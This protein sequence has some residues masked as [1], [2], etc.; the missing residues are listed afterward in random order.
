MV[1]PPSGFIDIVMERSNRTREAI[2]SANNSAFVETRG[3]EEESKEEDRETGKRIYRERGRDNKS[4]Y[5]IF[6]ERGRKVIRKKRVFFRMSFPSA[7]LASDMATWRQTEHAAAIFVFLSLPD[8]M[9]EAIMSLAGS[10][11]YR[12]DASSHACLLSTKSTVFVHGSN[13]TYGLNGNHM[14]QS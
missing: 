9:S 7:V 14:W 10:C 5:L 12:E 1:I 2:V 3:T 4:S 8:C 11:R 13:C 6:R